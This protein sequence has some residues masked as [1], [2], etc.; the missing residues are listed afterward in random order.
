[1][2][3]R[4]TQKAESRAAIVRS[5]ADLVRVGGAEGMSVQQA[6]R[7]AGLT[8]GAFYAHF[9]DKTEL[10][11]AAYQAAIDGMT[12]RVLSVAAAEHDGSS[13]LQV[14]DEYLSEAHRDHPELGCPL[15]SLLGEASHHGSPLPPTSL[16]RGFDAMRDLFM[17]VDPSIDRATADALLA[18][19]V[20]G[21][22]VARA[23]KGS[24]LSREVLEAAR[25]NARAL[26]GASPERST[27]PNTAPAD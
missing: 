9:A 16:A 3:Q 24:P 13:L 10:V 27:A 1:M 11:D 25:A 2:P 22:V 18:L 20:G 15:P 17:R 26:I 21:Q 14:I 7:G 12:Q 4:A 6:M 19:L 5:A 8:V 23:V